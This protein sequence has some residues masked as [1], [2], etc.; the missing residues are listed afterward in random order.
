MSRQ[1][2]RNRNNEPLSNEQIQQFAPSVFAGQAHDSCSD[3]YAFI[4]TVEVIEGL[5]NAGFAP[6]FASQSRSRI[7][8][9]E[10]F[11]RHMLRFRN[12]DQT[13]TQVGDTAVELAMT[14]SHDRTSQYEF[15]LGAFRLA[16][17]NGMIV[18]EGLVESVKVRHTGNIIERVIESTRS[19]IQLAPS[20]VE[21]IQTWKQILLSPAEQTFLAEGALALRFEDTAPVEAS[22]LLTVRR[23]ADTQNDLWTVFNR[24]Q[25]NAT[26]G[27]LRY[28]HVQRDPE[29]NE[30]QGTRRARTREVKGIDQNTKLNRELWTLAQKMAELK[31]K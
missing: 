1:T 6:V 13:P 15:S 31:T 9:K 25:E 29:T 22:R 5:R 26:Q 23:S 8:G 12:L 27:G 20:V 10:L 11:T 16:C 14:N 4:P 21:A 30:Y 3:R 2:N 7:A 28:T 18:S 17:L 24:I 19:L